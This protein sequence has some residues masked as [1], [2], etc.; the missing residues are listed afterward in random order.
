MIISEQYPHGD[1]YFELKK[2]KL[3]KGLG[4]MDYLPLKRVEKLKGITL[5]GEIVLTDEG[6]IQTMQTIEK[7]QQLCQKVTACQKP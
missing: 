2:G 1:G 4:Q 7:Y 5:V 6:K 3:A